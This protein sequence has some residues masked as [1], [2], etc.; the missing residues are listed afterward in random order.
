MSEHSY[1]NWARRVRYARMAKERSSVNYEQAIRDAHR[2]GGF[3]ASKIANMLG[4]KNRAQITKYLGGEPPAKIPHVELPVTLSLHGQ[5][6]DQRHWDRMR[7]G[8]AARGW[9][10]TD[11]NGAWHLSRAGAT[12][13]RVHWPAGPDEVLIELVRAVYGQPISAPIVTSLR[14][15]LPT[16]LV[17][18]FMR[19]HPEA[20]D[21]DI[22]EYTDHGFD[23]RVLASRTAQ[24]PRR[25]EEVSGRAVSVVD[26]EAILGFAAALIDQG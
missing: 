16:N 13:L 12:V 6:R 2:V 9:H 26:T 8:I 24:A 17:S 22:T 15:L 20:L 23:W 18:R 14:Q 19:E 3:S 10:E 21:W 1:D 11:D 7:A 4:I 25:D 5:G